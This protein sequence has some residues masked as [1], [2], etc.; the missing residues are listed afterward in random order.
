VGYELKFVVSKPSETDRTLACLHFHGHEA[1]KKP[2]CNVMFTSAKPHLTACSR[3]SNF[4]FQ[5]YCNTR[6]VTGEVIII[7]S[8]VGA[9]TACCACNTISNDSQ[10]LIRGHAGHEVVLCNSSN[11][12]YASL[13]FELMIPP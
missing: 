4:T 11:A 1:A 3:T 8:Y 6:P 7:N 9:P 2:L 10:N 5:L 13:L 12:G